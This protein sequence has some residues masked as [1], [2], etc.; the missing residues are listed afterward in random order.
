MHSAVRKQY[1]GIVNSAA[2]MKIGA[3]RLFPVLQMIPDRCQKAEIM[4]NPWSHAGVVQ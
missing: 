4:R 1:Q 2:D 3:R